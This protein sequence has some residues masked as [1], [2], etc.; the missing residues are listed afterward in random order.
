MD[1]SHQR[2]GRLRRY[3]SHGD[4]LQR[5]RSTP[6]N[7]DLSDSVSDET[8]DPTSDEAAEESTAGAVGTTGATDD[9]VVDLPPFAVPIPDPDTLSVLTDDSA[10]LDEQVLPTDLLAAVQRGVDADSFSLAEGIV[11]ALDGISGRTAPTPGLEADDVLDPGLT[12][13]TRTGTELLRG[14]DL[15]TAE[16]ALLEASLAFFTPTQA[17]L[18]RISR[19]DPW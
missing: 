19:P 6:S 4:R 2:R 7:T 5:R 12:G 10:Q 18:D 14:G 3:G 8:V 9:V 15:D 16:A 17:V 13:L 1:D 11:R